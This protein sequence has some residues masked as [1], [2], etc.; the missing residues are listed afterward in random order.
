MMRACESVVEV[1]I[2]VGLDVI[3][4]DVNPVVVTVEELRLSADQV[5]KQIDYEKQER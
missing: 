1:K 3:R 4:C 2:V 5:Y